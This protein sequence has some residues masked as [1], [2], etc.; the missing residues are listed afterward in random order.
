MDNPLEVRFK[1]LLIP[2]NS[3]QRSLL[4]TKEQYY[5]L[6]S[7]LKEAFISTTKSNRQYY[8]LG[9]YE[10]LK[11]GDVDKLIRKRTYNSEDPTY[12]AHINDMFD[13]TKRAIIQT[14]HGGRDKMTRSLT[15]Y[16]NIRRE[17][18]ELYKSLCAE[19]QKKR[20]RLTTKG[21]V[22]RPILSKDFLSRGQVDLIDM[23][24]MS[25]QSNKWILVYQDHLTKYCV[26][27]PL[28]SKR[29]AGVAYQLIDIFILLVYHRYYRV[30][31]DLNSLHMSLVNLNYYG[32]I[33]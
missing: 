25:Y 21:V 32:L 23:Q 4:L 30:T 16:A 27:S 6:I 10:I 1:D 12:F 18:I 29:A 2:K 5:E 31:T 26:L 14:G 3:E 13:I 8:I 11:C 28:T 17:S 33:F 19:C 9:H 7:S 15:N 22:V 24:S 20:K